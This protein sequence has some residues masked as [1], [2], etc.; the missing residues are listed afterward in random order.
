MPKRTIVPALL[1]MALAGAGPVLLAE[2]GALA[3]ECGAI[4]A[5]GRAANP[6]NYDPPK[7]YDMEAL[8]KARAIAAGRAAVRASCP[9][10]SSTWDRAGQRSLFCEGYAGGL[11]CEATATPA[12]G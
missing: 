7:H 11:A 5:S 3:A 12:H 6:L 8:A 1:T 10:S 4:S 9:G 2:C